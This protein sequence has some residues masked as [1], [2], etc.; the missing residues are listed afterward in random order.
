MAPRKNKCKQQR[1]AA[2]FGDITDLA[3]TS[4]VSS[5][6]LPVPATPGRGMDLCELGP[7]ALPE[8]ADEQPMEMEE[9]VFPPPTPGRDLGDGLLEGF[10][11]YSPSMAGQTDVEYELPAPGTQDLYQPTAAPADET[12]RD[13]RRG[14]LKLCCNLAVI[15]PYTGPR[16]VSL[17]KDKF[18]Y[19]HSTRP[20][21]TQCRKLHNKK[22]REINKLKKKQEALLK[23]LA[24]LPP[25]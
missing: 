25:V 11:L 21:N 14:P 22:R 17:P 15:K 10:S 6:P 16:T 3:S 20:S 4:A 12:P 8:P 18:P 2:L 7:P 5:N 19:V 13:P 23:K 24:T 9:F 1:M